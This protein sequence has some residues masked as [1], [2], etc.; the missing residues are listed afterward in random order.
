MSL[1]AQSFSVDNIEPP[2]WWTG[3][4]WNEVQLMVY[5]QQLQDLK[6]SSNNQHI[7]IKEVHFLENADYCFVDVNVKL[8]AKPGNYTLTF[9]KNGEENKV[10]FS[11]KEKRNN[12]NTHQGFDHKDVVYLITPDRFAQGGKKLDN[13]GKGYENIDRTDPEKR[14]GG[15]L[16]G[17]IE[18]L[19]YLKQLGITTIWL[20]PVL[21]NKMDRGSYHGYA[22]TDLYKIDPRFGTNE[23]YQQ[24]VQ[25]AHNLGIKVIFDHV[26]NHI[27]VNHPWVNNPPTS[28]WLHGTKS[29]H[30]RDKHYMA[31][32]VD[33][34]ADPETPELLDKFWFD[35]VMPDMNQEQHFLKKYLIQ[36]TIWWIEY[37]GIDGIREDTYPYANQLFL[38]DW[39]EAILKE[40]PNF[41]IVGE[42]WNN[43]PGIISQFQHGVNDTNLPALMDFPLMEAF[44][45]YLQGKGKLQNIYEIFTHDF[46]YADPK[47]LMTFIDNH[48]TQR[49]FYISDGNTDKIKQCLTIAMT[50]RGI[51]Q[52]LYGT[53]I[54]LKGGENH[55]DVRE[56]FPGGFPNDV[57]N[58]FNLNE[59]TTSE[60]DM[61]KFIQQL[62]AL[63]KA[64]PSLTDGQFIHYPLK[65]TDDI[66]KY[67]KILDNE[68]ILIVINGH[69]EKRTVPFEEIQH[70]LDGYSKFLNLITNESSPISAGLPMKKWGVGIF[71]LE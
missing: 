12:K 28:D 18:R 63:R 58:A 69:D 21:E 59:Q 50:T 30:E 36:N 57:R 44:R 25:S 27:G 20:N 33:P 34:Y 60:K 14:H 45:A 68:K 40:Y 13:F 67:F 5:G 10:E 47:N 16:L 42:V 39:A 70:Q 52:L 2:F 19:D 41:N 64:H 71:L 22:A 23:T 26:A 1:T 56:D 35:D 61:F 46:L 54:N 15:N 4:E 48:D 3:M 9:E 38:K 49:G 43:A 11:L 51:P 32:I 55:V 53:E 29:N 65:W 6:I 66:Y 24:L 37:A 7:E 8:D 31:S 62:I 17:I